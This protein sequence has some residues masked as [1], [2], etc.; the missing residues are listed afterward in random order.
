MFAVWD[1]PKAVEDFDGNAVTDRSPGS[2]RLDKDQV[3]TLQSRQDLLDGP[4]SQGGLAADRAHRWPSVEAVLIG[5]PRKSQKYQ[6]LGWRHDGRREVE[7]GVDDPDAHGYL[8]LVRL[9]T[10]W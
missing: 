5:M 6:T 10:G 3:L 8:G 9:R 4:R 1:I 7:H 2:P